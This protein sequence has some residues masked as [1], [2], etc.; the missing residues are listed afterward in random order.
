M[1]ISRAF[2]VRPVAT[3]LLMLAVLL[4]GALGY[5]LLPRAALPQVDYPTIQVV[6]LYPGASPEVTATSITAPLERQFGA[7]AGLAQMSST[8]SAGAAVVNLRFGLEVSL[9]VAE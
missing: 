2:I 9:D 3:W 1:D 6:T 7:M 5:R 4:C 8:S